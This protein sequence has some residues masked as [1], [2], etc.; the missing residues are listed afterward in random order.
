MARPSI[1]TIL[2]CAALIAAGCAGGGPGT[3]TSGSGGPS[4]A[5]AEAS[6]T[7]TPVQGSPIP[8][9]A[10][11]PQ[12]V[13]KA[14]IPGVIYPAALVEADGAVWALGHTDAK[15]N[16]ID[17]TTDTITDS[18]SIG[19]SYATGGVLVD[20]KLWALDFTDRQVVG[21]DPAERKV[22]AKV[23]VGIDG[24]W[25]KGGDVAVWAMGNDAHELMRIDPTTKV[26]T[27]LAVDPRCGSTPL[28]A[29]GF[30]WLVSYSGHLCKLD[31]KTGD[32][33]AELDGLGNAAQW[34][35]WAADR[36][37]LPNDEGGA[38]VVDPTGMKIEAV[39]PPPPAGTVKGA[40][41]QLSAPGS[42][43]SV[44]M[45]GDDKGVW[46]R[47][48]GATVGRLDLSGS[49]RWTVYAGL[50]ASND[51]APMLLG[52]DSFWAADVDGNSI[53]RAEVPS[54]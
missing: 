29:G 30:V 6:G 52:F 43:G 33:L 8:S 49:P 38:V 54:R 53:I 4:P 48:L 10:E 51:G 28:A 47:Y 18:I 5:A 1:V 16:R 44:S 37:I 2:A 42:Q 31:P 26:I 36:V 3:P 25:L 45:L 7:P 41:Y 46:V 20:G 12:V 17:P 40:K 22:V 24:G 32:V 34:L 50:P 35:F 23:P 14:T 39:V 11:L 9:G 27:R 21:V 19:G 13:V 15:W